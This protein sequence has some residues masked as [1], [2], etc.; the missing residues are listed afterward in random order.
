MNENG[1]GKP[2]VVVDGQRGPTCESQAQA[3]AEAKRINQLQEQQTGQ[4]AG[5]SQKATVKLNIF[6]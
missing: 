3:E 4:P 2:V 5:E 1:D 6:G